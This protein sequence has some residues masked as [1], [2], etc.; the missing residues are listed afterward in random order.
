MS[1]LRK[2]TEPGWNSREAAMSK[3]SMWLVAGSLVI[4]AGLACQAAP[5]AAPTPDRKSVV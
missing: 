1:I 4:G 2:T 3:G 5:D